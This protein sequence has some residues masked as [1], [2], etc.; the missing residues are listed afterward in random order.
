MSEK[1]DGLY[2]VNAQAFLALQDAI[3]EV[4][5]SLTDGDEHP[6]AAADIDWPEADVRAAARVA[7]TA[8]T[9]GIIKVT[10]ETILVPEPSDGMKEVAAEARKAL[11]QHEKQQLN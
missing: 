8:L 6:I 7:I 2:N 9:G 11:A 5:G 4:A 10:N 3:R 1:I